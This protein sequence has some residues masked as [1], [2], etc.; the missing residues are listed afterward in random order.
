MK[1]LMMIISLFLFETKF[2][3]VLL[4]C[5]IIILGLY[6]YFPTDKNSRK[7]GKKCQVK[8]YIKYS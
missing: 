6:L 5:Q 1:F 7:E 3:K 2:S 4:V 8:F